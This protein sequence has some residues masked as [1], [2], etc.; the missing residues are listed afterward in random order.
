MIAQLPEQ[1][2]EQIVRTKRYDAMFELAPG[3]AGAL[4]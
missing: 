2:W 1:A 3:E 4:S